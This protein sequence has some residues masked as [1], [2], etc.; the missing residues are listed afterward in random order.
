MFECTPGSDKTSCNLADT[1]ADLRDF[2]YNRASCSHR[3]FTV[4]A[5]I[6]VTLPTDAKFREAFLEELA[7]VG[8]V[9]FLSDVP[10]N[11]RSSELAE[12]DVLISWKLVDELK[13][14]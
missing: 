3:G 10:R 9:E 7:P 14:S 4:L 2:K 12:A 5:K 8:D 6:L 1:E 11:K 13:P